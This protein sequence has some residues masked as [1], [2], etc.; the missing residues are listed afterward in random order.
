MINKKI[1]G[2]DVE[3]MELALILTYQP[4]GNVGGITKP[5]LYSTY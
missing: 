2:Y 5:F 1:I 4:I 3:S